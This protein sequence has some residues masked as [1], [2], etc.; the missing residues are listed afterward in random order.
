MPYGVR[1]METVKVLGYASSQ[2]S[3]PK[4]SNDNGMCRRLFDVEAIQRE[5][6]RPQH[7]ST[8]NEIEL[9]SNEPL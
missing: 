3:E 2:D 5:R 4:Q 7:G 1:Q 8:T 6:D 9:Y